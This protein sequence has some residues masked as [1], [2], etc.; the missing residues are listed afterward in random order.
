MRVT[1]DRDLCEANGVC[2]GLVPGVFRLD[3]STGRQIGHGIRLVQWLGGRKR[4]IG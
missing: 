2:A 1:V 3:P 4:V